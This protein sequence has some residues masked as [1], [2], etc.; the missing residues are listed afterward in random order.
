MSDYPLADAPDG[1]THCQYSQILKLLQLSPLLILTSSVNGVGKSY[2]LRQVAT[3]LVLG[4]QIVFIPS[5]YHQGKLDASLDYAWRNGG[6][7]VVTASSTPE[8]LT[9]LRFASSVLSLSP[10]LE[11]TAATRP[12][13]HPSFK[14]VVE[15]TCELY[16]EKLHQL[17]QHNPGLLALRVDLVDDHSLYTLLCRE[18]FS[19]AKQQESFASVQRVLPAQQR[20]SLHLLAALKLLPTVKERAACLGY[21]LR[22]ETGALRPELLNA[23]EEL[24]S[25]PTPK[26]GAKPARPPKPAPVEETDSAQ[27]QQQHL[28]ELVVHHEE[29]TIQAAT[30]PVQAI[31]EGDYEY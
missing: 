26:A 20:F 25:G 9:A 8:L 14:F 5:V 23:L 18:V 4:M 12:E 7:V 15:F 10:V 6:V 30:D 2:L 24:A 13:R 31:V 11:L 27:V 17:F 1:N 19:S 28:V 3:Q 22:N 16:G 29:P 21:L